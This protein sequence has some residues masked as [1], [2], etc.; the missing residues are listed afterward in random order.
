MQEGFP[1]KEAA[2]EWAIQWQRAHGKSEAWI[3]QRILGMSLV[4]AE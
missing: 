2:V 1:S 4:K 3:K